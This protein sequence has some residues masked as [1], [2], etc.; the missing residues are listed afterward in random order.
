MTD[1][2]APTK[3]DAASLGRKL[4]DFTKTLSPGELALWQRKVAQTL[5][6]KGDVQ[7][8][9]WVL[10]GYEYDPWTGQWYEV[11]VWEDDYW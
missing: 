2:V 4:A 1:T 9:D 6:Q 5:P 7:G 11:W 3:E 10:E 8:Y